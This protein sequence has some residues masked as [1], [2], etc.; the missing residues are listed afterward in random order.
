MTVIFKVGRRL[1][2]SVS[3]RIGAA[4]RNFVS[5]QEHFWLLF[6]QTLQHVKKKAD[7]APEE[8]ITITLSKE[9]EDDGEFFIDWLVV[10]ITSP[11]H[12]KELQEYNECLGFY[13]NFS[14]LKPV[15]NER[16]K[17]DGVTPLGAKGMVGKMKR[18]GMQV[19]KDNP[20]ADKLLELGLIITVEK[21]WN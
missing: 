4:V 6:N 7:A 2:R 14:A 10:M 9:R 15:L 5:T 3:A 1:P 8:Q 21:S 20:I 13:D 18:K 12:E 16:I 11:I 17:E 19:L